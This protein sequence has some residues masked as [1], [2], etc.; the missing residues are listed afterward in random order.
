MQSPGLDNV[1]SIKISNDNAI[2]FRKFEVYVGKENSDICKLNLVSSFIS[3]F[4]HLFI[5]HLF[6]ARKKIRQS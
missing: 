4:T 6:G 5:Q 3:S 2:T 1:R